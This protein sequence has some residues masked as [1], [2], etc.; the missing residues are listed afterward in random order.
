[1]LLRAVLITLDGLSCTSSSWIEL[2]LSLV[3]VALQHPK[4]RSLDESE[5]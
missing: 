5:A 2:F 3:A 1:L 4:G